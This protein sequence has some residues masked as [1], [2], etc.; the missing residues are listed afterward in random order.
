MARKDHTDNRAGDEVGTGMGLRLAIGGAVTVG[1][2][3]S[4]YLLS[5][6][7]RR[8]VADTFRGRR[9]SPL[10]ERVQEALWGDPLLAHRRIT[11]DEVEGEVFLTGTVATEVERNIAL[12]RARAVT[13]VRQVTDRIV[14]D[15]TLRRRWGTARAI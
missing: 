5:R 15:P 10:A 2:L 3:V 12:E 11:V 1:A 4:G 14:L 9:P 7:G 13:G 8:L 6:H